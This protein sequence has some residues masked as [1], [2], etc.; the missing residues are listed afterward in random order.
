M[1]QSKAGL[2]FC[3]KLITVFWL[4]ILTGSLHT[5]LFVKQTT[6]ARLT[7]TSTHADADP[8]VVHKPIESIG[9]GHKHH[10]G[11]EH[12]ESCWQC[13]KAEWRR[14]FV[15]A[16]ST[17]GY[18][19]ACPNTTDWPP[20]VWSQQISDSQDNILRHPYSNEFQLGAKAAALGEAA[21][22]P[23]TLLAQHAI[24]QN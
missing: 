24:W 15:F 13:V 14:H 8:A 6:L 20:G 5:G 2:G 1:K 21:A 22:L 9:R 4:G 18:L 16:N 23:G 3:V 10:P 19:D 12:A 7:V 17:G 11:A